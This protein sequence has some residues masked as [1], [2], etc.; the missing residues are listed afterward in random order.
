MAAASGR[1]RL[2]S[3]PRPRP[4][5]GRLGPEKAQRALPSVHHGPARRTRHTPRPGGQRK[6][7]PPAGQSGPAEPGRE[8]RAGSNSPER[9]RGQARAGQRKGKRREKSGSKR[10]ER[11]C[12]SAAQTLRRLHPPQREPSGAAISA[13]FSLVLALELRASGLQRRRAD[14][15]ASGRGHSGAL[16]GQAALPSPDS[17]SSP[18]ASSR[19]RPRRSVR[20]RRPGMATL[21]APSSVVSRSRWPP[22]WGMGKARLVAR[23][24]PVWNLGPDPSL[25]VQD[26]LPYTPAPS[27]MARMELGTARIGAGRKGI[28]DKDEKALA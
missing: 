16:Q 9:R 26:R 11:G 17:P 14:E 24:V 28:A 3:G 15:T 22:G 12:K 27:Q 8:R 5:P 23:R 25:Q 4:G 2:C 19:L 13:P 18:L 1:P 7:G 20:A 21:W 10:R 6:A